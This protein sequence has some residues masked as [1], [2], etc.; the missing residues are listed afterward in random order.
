MN[1]TD[2]ATLEQVRAECRKLVTSRAMLAGA[3]SAV[4]GAVVGVTADVGLLL[5]M[6]PQINR[7]FGLDP[8]QIDELDEQSRQ[9]VFLLAGS[10]GNA[11]IGK[12]ITEKLIVSILTKVGV[13][14]GVKSVAGW[15]PIIGSGIAAT[16]GFAMMKSVG[17]AHVEDC[18][19]VV[20]QV[21]ASKQD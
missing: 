9:Q 21:L 15:V 1:I 4:P 11:I 10:A 20:K 7:K 12:V 16:V 13:R 2:L 14:V 6:L 19:R 3:A 5:Q 8:E 17:N 18:Y